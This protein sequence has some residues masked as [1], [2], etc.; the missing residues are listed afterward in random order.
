LNS[1]E[2]SRRIEE[3][4]VQLSEYI[5]QKGLKLDDREILKISMEL[6]ELIACYNELRLRTS[7]VGCQ[8]D[9]DDNTRGINDPKDSG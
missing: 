4:R 9:D 5:L 7:T 2:L 3:K 8:K 1:V 6:D